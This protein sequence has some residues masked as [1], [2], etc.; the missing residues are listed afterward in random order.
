MEKNLEN[1]HLQIDELL[2]REVAE[3][4]LKEVDFP[5]GCLVTVTKV[6]TTK[7]IK[8][9]EIY[10]SVLPKAF[11]GKVLSLLKTRR[12]HFIYLIRKKITIKHVPEIRFVIDEGGNE[13]FYAWEYI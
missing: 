2:K 6:K 5:K 3:L 7:D 4:L 8:E 1:R 10:I 12:K 13:E 11:T 9:A